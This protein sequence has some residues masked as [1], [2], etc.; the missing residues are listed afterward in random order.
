MIIYCIKNKLN[1]K[2]YVGMTKRPLNSRWKQHISDSFRLN[3]WEWNTHLGNA[4]KK[5]GVENFKIFVIE[6]CKSFEEMVQ[7]EI[8][9]IKERKSF[10]KFGGYNMTEGGE[11][12]LAFKHSEETKKKIGLGQIGK[13]MSLEARKKCSIAKQGKYIRGKHPKATKLL[14]N[15]SEVFECIRDFSEAYGIPCGTINNY[16]VR[17]KLMSFTIKGIKIQRISNA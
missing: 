11:G 9:H 15:D 17:K 14:I 5:Y 13:I 12:K 6:E 2:E 16:F 4:L 10:N 3:S 7:K 8:Y 1:D